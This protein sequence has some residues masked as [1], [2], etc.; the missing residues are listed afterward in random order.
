V[1]QNA[2][3]ISAYDAGYNYAQTFLARGT[4]NDFC[5]YQFTETYCL[6]NRH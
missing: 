6:G 2:S 1:M 3:A 4:F 5:G